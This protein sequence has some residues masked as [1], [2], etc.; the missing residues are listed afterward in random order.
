MSKSFTMERL[1]EKHT[2]RILRERKV[3]P[4]DSSVKE[5]E[6]KTTSL[7]V[8]QS[9]FKIGSGEQKHPHSIKL[10][11]NGGKTTK[12][13]DYMHLLDKHYDENEVIILFYQRATVSIYGN[14]LDELY[15][16]LDDRR[17]ASIS[18]YEKNS[19]RGSSEN[20]EEAIITAIQVEYKDK[21]IEQQI[22]QIRQ[23][24]YNKKGNSNYQR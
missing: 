8:V 17:I 19:L 4:I 23:H 11:L 10:Y 7:P 13:M 15:N 6:K 3:V 12:S 9:C 21:D 5:P 16:R 24:A 14:N 1:P 2:D 18:V 22:E 20:E